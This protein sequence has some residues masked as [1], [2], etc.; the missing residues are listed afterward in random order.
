M[1]DL[2]LVNGKVMPLR[3]ARV[4]VLDRGFL[5]A[6]GAYEVLR[7]Y[8]GR[9]FQ[10]EAHLQRLQASLQGLRIP[11]PMP[12][13]RLALKLQRLLRQ[14]GLQDARLY[15]QVTRGAGPRTQAF[16]ARI[17]P[18]LVAY[19]EAVPKMRPAL[20]QR[21][22]SALTLA[23][24]RWARCDLKSIA[25][26]PNVLAKQ[27]ALDAGAYEAIFLGPGGVVREAST[28]NVFMVRGR[29]LRTHPRGAGIL[30]G[31]SR[32][33]VLE[34]AREA[35]LQVRESKFTRATLKAADEVFLSSTMQEILSIVRIDGRPIGTGRPGPVARDLAARFRTR[36]H[37]LP[38][39]AGRGRVAGTRRHVHPTVPRRSKR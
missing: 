27:W 17:R 35:G 22:V 23:D 3:A 8:D 26:L 2:A 34:L 18:T 10:L 39:P 11:P 12:L 32:S 1:A 31:V 16:P 4:R 38:L 25:L 37:A 29:V 33:V 13:P 19:V 14:S 7:S 9:I 36:T 5:L 28:A 30:P 15:V 21:G 24:P 6:D 20:R